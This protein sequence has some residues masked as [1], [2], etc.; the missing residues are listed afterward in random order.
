MADAPMGA[1][2]DV[3]PSRP[4]PAALRL[5]A[6]CLLPTLFSLLLLLLMDGAEA[7][8]FRY[9]VITWKRMKKNHTASV[10][11]TYYY[12]FR[13]I[14]GWDSD[15]AAYPFPQMVTAPARTPFPYLGITGGGFD[16]G[17]NTTIAQWDGAHCFSLATPQQPLMTLFTECDFFH[18]YQW[19]GIYYASYLSCC[20]LDK[21]NDFL[22]NN[23]ELQARVWT[24]VVMDDYF[25]SSLV[26]AWLP[27]ATVPSNRGEPIG[28]QQFVAFDPYGY[29]ITY[30]H[31]NTDQMSGFPLNTPGM[32][33]SVPPYWW[34]IGETTGLV[35]WYNFTALSNFHF[36][37]AQILVEHEDTNRT[38]AVDFLYRIQIVDRLCIGPFA[39]NGGC[40]GSRYQLCTG[41]SNCTDPL[42]PESGCN[43]KC[44]FPSIPKFIDPTPKLG[45]LTV[46]YATQ[47]HTFPV[48]SNRTGSHCCEPGEY[49]YYI[50]GAL[51]LGFRDYINQFGT[52]PLVALY[53]W[54]PTVD[55]AGLSQVCW[56]VCA[57]NKQISP[58]VEVCSAPY[59][60]AI[61]VSLKPNYPPVI[62]LPDEVFTEFGVIAY[63][64]TWKYFTDLYVTDDS[65]SHEVE[66]WVWVDQG[67]LELGYWPSGL[68]VLNGTNGTSTMK[69][70]LYGSLDV[71]N[72]ALYK[73]KWKGN[74]GNAKMSIWAN[75]HGWE[76][77][78][79]GEPYT[80]LYDFK[81][82]PI[83]VLPACNNPC[84]SNK[85]ILTKFYTD[86][87]GQL[88]TANTNWLT[89]D[90]CWDN[91]LGVTCIQ[92]NV[93][94]LSLPNNQLNGTLPCLLGCLHYLR[95]L[96]LMNNNIS[97]LI[98]SKVGELSCL[99]IFGLGYNKLSWTIPPEMGNMASM[100]F[101]QL[102]DNQLIGSVPST[103]GNLP[104]LQELLLQNNK[105]SGTLPASLWTS[106]TL[107]LNY[108]WLYNNNLR[109]VPPSWSIERFYRE[110]ELPR[111][112]YENRM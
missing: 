67:T 3:L 80:T 79:Q 2:T 9:G 20:R 5:P 106:S 48:V 55:D 85:V 47:T 76:G 73:M 72:Y 111:V 27:I 19:P 69:V 62:H 59:C 46:I 81:E 107:T 24:T 92:D 63:H 18:E 109:D 8:H 52:N 75:D 16:Y 4:R 108:M 97:G 95:E 30:T 110:D 71:I 11:S 43:A 86:L 42:N 21:D 96:Y 57:A 104:N 54:T 41:D 88:W 12:R 66:V 15:F 1:A 13:V 6:M 105:L 102:H 112:G 83:L 22:E 50:E 39:G 70:E 93:V 87:N 53:P 40:N 60:F 10:L 35:A 82:F 25:Q 17:D 103:L 26:S 77:M 68:K 84:P 91:W 32:P 14:A 74:E 100:R 101:L 56:G 29:D 94:T 61:F 51:P 28:Y 78:G 37:N 23:A 98:P 99:Y 33:Q 36:Y 34:T 44:D 31:S 7:T 65:G 49:L 89:G 64:D 45:S 90:P 58:F 38:V